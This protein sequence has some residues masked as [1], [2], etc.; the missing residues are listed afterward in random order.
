[1]KNLDIFHE[2]FDV[3]PGD[4]MWLEPKERVVIW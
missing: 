4:E 1:V 2:T 3:Q